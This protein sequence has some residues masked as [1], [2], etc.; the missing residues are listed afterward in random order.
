MVYRTITTMTPEAL[1]FLNTSRDDYIRGTIGTNHETCPMDMH[2]ADKA[3]FTVRSYTLSEL[4]AKALPF[5]A[6]EKMWGYRPIAE[7]LDSL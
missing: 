5:Q 4:R 2:R 1:R 3:W 6:D 7:F